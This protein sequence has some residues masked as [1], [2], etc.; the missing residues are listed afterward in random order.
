MNE[1]LFHHYT[2]IAVFIMASITFIFTLIVVPPYGRHIRNGWGP[3]V[4]N[5]AG[6][7]IMEVPTVVV[8]IGIYLFGSNRLSAVPLFFLFIYQFH[9]IYRTFIFPFL[10]KSKG[11]TM[12]LTVALSGF[13]Y[14]CLNA[15]V[16]ARWIS[17]IGNYSNSWFSDS[18]FIIGTILFFIGFGLNFYSDKILRNLRKPGETGYKIPYGGLFKW[19]SAPNYMSEIIEWIGFALATYSLPGLSFAIFTA[20]NVIPRAIANHKW[21][22]EKFEDYPKERTAVIPFIL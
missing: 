3:S 18:R 8:F 4:S 15:Y 13:F 11:K 10:L 6:W 2:T 7:I 20:S 1:A 21:Y 5:T 17:E 19:V 16:I 22:K 14:N 12:P 9:Y